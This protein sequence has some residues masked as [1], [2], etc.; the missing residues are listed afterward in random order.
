MDQQWIV[1]TI[2]AIA[3]M[4]A[5]EAGA[6]NRLAFTVADKEARGYVASLMESLGMTVLIDAIG[7]VVGRLEG[8]EPQLPPVAMGSHVDT[9]P[10]G[11]T[12]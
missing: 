1:E 11:G 2:N 8:S 10:H 12:L 9:V 6:A 7:N 4:G 5:D 3:S